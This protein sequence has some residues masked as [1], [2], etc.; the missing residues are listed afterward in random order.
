[1]YAG[2]VNDVATRIEKAIVRRL[3]H[4]DRM[5]V[6]R[7]T[8]QIYGTHVEGY[9]RNDDDL[10][11]HTSTTLRM[12]SKQARSKGQSRARSSLTFSLIV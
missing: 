10:G 7:I 11:V 3:G 12:S 8:T 2:G 5:D 1:M 6:S 4:M 9:L